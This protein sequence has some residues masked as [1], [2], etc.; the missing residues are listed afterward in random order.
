MSMPGVD[1]LYKKLKACPPEKT[2][3]A[4]WLNIS[5]EIFNYMSQI[6]AGSTGAPGIILFNSAI[7]ANLCATLPMD[8]D[9]SNFPGAI[10]KNWQSAMMAS[11]ITPGTVIDPGTWVTSTA[12]IMTVPAVPATVTTLSA[13][14]STLESGLKNV[15]ADKDAPKAMAEAFHNAFLEMQF[16]CIGLGPPPASPPIPKPFPAK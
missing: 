8:K 12:D 9:G 6:Q 13:A 2:A 1:H 7:F 16:T 15:K 14:V 4:G 11:T 10:A 5:I 3:I